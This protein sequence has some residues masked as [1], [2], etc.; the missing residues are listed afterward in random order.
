MTNAIIKRKCCCTGIDCV[1]PLV[2]CQPDC[3]GGR[4][5]QT[6]IGSGQNCCDPGDP[7][8]RWYV[9]GCDMAGEEPWCINLT[10]LDSTGGESRCYCFD[11]NINGRPFN[12]NTDTRLTPEDLG[13]LFP[14]CEECCCNNSCNGACCLPCS[15]GGGCVGNKTRAECAALGGT[16]QGEGSSCTN[17]QCPECPKPCC[18]T[19]T[20][21]CVMAT[22]AECA[23]LGGVHHPNLNSC[24]DLTCP[25]PPQPCN[26][27]CPPCP[28]ALTATLSVNM[29]MSDL[30]CGVVD[31]QNLIATL[32]MPCNLCGDGYPPCCG[33]GGQDVSVTDSSHTPF[34]CG[35][36]PGRTNA[37]ATISGFITTLTTPG[38]YGCRDDGV[39]IC[40]GAFG[41]VYRW[42]FFFLVQMIG[43]IGPS[44]GGTPIGGCSLSSFPTEFFNIPEQGPF[45]I[46]TGT[47]CPVL[48]ITA[49][50]TSK[51][52]GSQRIEI[53]APHLVVG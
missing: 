15:A 47:T 3:S 42:G 9:I 33:W 11:P 45:P 7:P 29:V 52:C 48:D 51:V 23:N 31:S 6:P 12:A 37:S 20:G 13:Q 22:A 43:S 4:E 25:Q 26:P 30:S 41:G 32:I 17:V 8:N 5:G 44:T 40:S 21:A 49:P 50:S 16:F 2:P 53:N 19:D 1:I 10:V 46:C 34:V 14:T 36:F 39:T 27:W 18:V 24:A 35:G 38:C 28:S